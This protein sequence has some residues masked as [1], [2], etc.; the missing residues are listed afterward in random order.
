M[1]TTTASTPVVSH[2]RAPSTGPLGRIVFGSMA[3]GIL[4]AAI[5]TL[6]VLPSAPEAV[7]TGGALIAFASGWAVLA[8]ASTRF[9]SRPQRWANVPAAVLGAT[10]VVL[11]ATDPGDPTLTRLGLVWAPALVGL[12]LWVGHRARRGLP[13]RRGLPVLGAVGVM[14][15]A[16]LGGAFQAAASDPFEAAGPMPGRLV[17]VGGYRLHISCRGTGSPTV[18]LLNGLGE[19][20]PEWARVAPAVASQARVCVYDRAGQGWSEDSPRPA[21]ATSTAGDL[22][23][24]LAAAGEHGPYVLAGH[25]SGGVY[26]LTYAHLHRPEVAG[27]VLLDS[28]SPRQAELIPSFEGEYQV[29]RRALAIAPALFRLGAGRLLASAATPTLPG[30]AGAQ[31]S[32]FS[33]S[34]R[35]MRSMRAEQLALPTAF[36]QARATTTLGDLPLVVLTA[37]PNVDGKPGWGS[38]QDELASLSTNS[39][40]TIADLDHAA[41]LDDPAGAALSVGAISDVLRAARDHTPVTHR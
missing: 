8:W 36:A 26:A 25:S 6:V 31:A 24:L 41:Y 14:L 20:S 13:D 34:P 22:H 15:I 10:G 32:S 5:S 37:K 19:T 7:V 33:D 30:G 2:D 23:R 18:V 29:M 4:A 27:I 38:A 40:H 16:G 3:F 17:D 12:A 21:D 11:V 9:T 1:S 35:G 39:R 28:A